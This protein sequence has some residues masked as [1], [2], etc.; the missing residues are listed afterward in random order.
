MRLASRVL[1][2]AL[3]GC[4]LAV[5][6]ADPTAATAN[7]LDALTLADEAKPTE[8]KA[9]RPWRVFLEG[10]G[11]SSRHAAQ[12]RT[13]SARISLDAR[14]DTTLSPGLRLVL[15]NRLD[16]VHDEAE[17][18]LESVNTLREAYLGW[19]LTDTT[20]LDFGRVNVRH[21]AALG[22]NPTDWFKENALRGVVSPDPTALR[23]NRQGSV[24]L[25]GQQLWADGSVS[26]TLSPALERDRV[27][28][29]RAVSLDLGAT[30]PRHRWLLAGSWRVA[31]GWTPELLVHGSEG[32]APQLGFNLSAL[33]GDA[34][35]VFGE[36]TIG[37]GP[38]LAARAGL[39]PEAER[40]QRRGALGF[41]WTT[42]LNLSL[43]VEAEYNGAAPDRAQW[44]ALQGQGLQ[45]L[46]AASALQDLPARRAVFVYAS[47]KDALMRRLD[48]AAFVRQE[49]ETD[50]RSQWLELRHRWDQVDLAVQ[51]LLNSGDAGSVYRLVPLRRAVEL[52]LR[53]YL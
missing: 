33:A 35:V 6:A 19:S 24:V 50:S 44:Q 39:E 26:L 34:V 2:A 42:P 3:C 31:Q 14:V 23:E 37:T 20:N 52:S 45:L 43:T 10:A 30:N 25:R 7:E 41:T 11:V 40:R 16:L 38:T 22:Y 18:P 49:L 32:S 5:L 17:P 12:D 15:S 47:W 29:E 21:G 36:A 1:L 28:D 27:R 53:W 48:L 4:P 9:A 13:D 51:V 46:G 8:D